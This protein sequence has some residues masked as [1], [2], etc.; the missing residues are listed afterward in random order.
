[1]PEAFQRE[2]SVD[3]PRVPSGRVALSSRLD[4]GNVAIGLKEGEDYWIV[5]NPGALLRVCRGCRTV[6]Q[7]HL[8]TD[9]FCFAE[10][11]M[12]DSLRTT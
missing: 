6:G 3:Q 7:T 9:Y 5:L 4:N 11:Y 10:K 1:M 2:S 12:L 8:D